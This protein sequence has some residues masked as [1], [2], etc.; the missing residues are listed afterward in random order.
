MCNSC[1]LNKVAKI[2]QA[3]NGHNNIFESVLPIHKPINVNIK[4]GIKIYN[5]EILSLKQ[6][7]IIIQDAKLIIMHMYIIYDNI[8]ITLGFMNSLIE[9]SL[10]ENFSFFLTHIKNDK[11]NNMNNIAHTIPNIHDG[12]LK[13]TFEPDVFLILHIP[14]VAKQM[15]S[16]DNNI[17]QSFTFSIN[18]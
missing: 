9:S 3:I 4:I 12:G 6:P 13:I 15:I 10:L 2:N 11:P 5:A 18:I 7:Y 1:V 8:F 14:D 17:K 16:G